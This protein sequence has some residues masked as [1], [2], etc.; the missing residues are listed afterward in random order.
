MVPIN[1]VTYIRP[2]LVDYMFQIH[3]TDCYFPKFDHYYDV[4]PLLHI[5]SYKYVTFVYVV[6]MTH[7]HAVFYS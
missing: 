1:A 5:I 6:K 7:L 2:L 3:H 4:I